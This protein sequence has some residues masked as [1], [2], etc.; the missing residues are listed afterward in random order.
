[1]TSSL[2]GSEMCIRDRCYCMVARVGPRSLTTAWRSSCLST[3]RCKSGPGSRR[4]QEEEHGAKE[5]KQ[6]GK[7][8]MKTLARGLSKS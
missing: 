3:S 8:S 5:V 2:V 6:S 7:R 4:Q 1:M